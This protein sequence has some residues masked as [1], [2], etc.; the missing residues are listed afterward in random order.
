M[1]QLPEKL[2][3]TIYKPGKQ[4]LNLDQIKRPEQAPSYYEALSL[5]AMENGVDLKNSKVLE[6][7]S[8]RGMLLDYA[9]ERGVNVTGVDFNPKGKDHAHQV[10][11]FIEK[12]PFADGSF[13]VAYSTFMMDKVYIQDKGAMINEAYRILKKG[14]LYIAIEPRLRPDQ[15]DPKL[16]TLVN[17][18]KQPRVFKKL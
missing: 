11:A 14:G 1:D 6:M 13:D 17:P 16:F 5:A 18:G 4:H 2:K 12:L 3:A 10:A 9:R 8:G 7:G 15:V